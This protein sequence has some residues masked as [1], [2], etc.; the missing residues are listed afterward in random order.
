M[1]VFEIHNVSS[2]Q[3]FFKELEFHGSFR[4]LPPPP[5]DNFATV[6]AV[7]TATSVFTEYIFCESDR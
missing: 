4:D 3:N 6:K 2:F 1:K 7:A 5:A